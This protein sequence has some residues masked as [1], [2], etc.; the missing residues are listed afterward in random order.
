[1]ENMHK[2]TFFPL[3]N[4]DS[5]RMDTANG[6]KFLFDYATRRDP[7]DKQDKRIDLSAELK[8]DLKTSKRNG[9]D[10]VGFTHLDD[11]HVCGSPE[12]FYFEHAA[13]YQ[14][15]DRARIGQMWVPAAVIIEDRPDGDAGIVQAEARYRLKNKRGIRVFSRPDA[16]REWMSKQGLK[17]ADYTDFIID[18][19]RVVPD[20][21]LDQDGIEFFVHS[22][23]AEHCDD[24]SYIERNDASLVLQVRFADKNTRA[25]VILGADTTHE[26][27]TSIVNVTRYHKREDRLRWN[28]FK[29]PHHCSYLSLGPDKGKDKTDPVPEVKWL[30]EEQS[31]EGCYIVSTSDPIPSKDTDQ[32]PHRQAANYYK[33]VVAE[34]DGDFMVTMEHPNSDAPEPIVFEIGTEGVDY[35]DAGSARKGGVVS[36]IAAARG[37][38][39]PPAQRVGFG[40]ND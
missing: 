17:I 40:R 2:I 6:K 25:D 8:K 5:C 23:F 3:G 38:P 4:A 32:P 31:R 19:G 28:I 21:K 33:G 14:S 24:G 22:P 15:E 7:K 20:F 11:D 34:R 37:T 9:Y 35:Q 1:L 39:A 36:A 12:F 10:V 16:L 13:K 30:F 29:L 18:A 27:W 26:I